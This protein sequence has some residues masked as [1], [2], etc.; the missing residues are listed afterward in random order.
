MKDDRFYDK[1]KHTDKITG[2]PFFQIYPNVNKFIRFDPMSGRINV[3]IDPV[4]VITEAAN[5][6]TNR[7][8]ILSQVKK[9]LQPKNLLTGVGTLLLGRTENSM[10]PGEVLQNPIYLTN[11][12]GNMIQSV[13]KSAKEEGKKGIVKGILSG[14]L[15]GLS[16]LFSLKRKN[17]KYIK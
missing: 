10:T 1:L 12:I 14:A 8:Q 17:L 13:Y 11:F 15:S 5:F 16:G 2:R 7:R 3:H 6:I 4:D 9:V